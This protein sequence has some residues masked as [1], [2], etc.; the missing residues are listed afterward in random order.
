MYAQAIV[1]LEE[2]RRRVDA[3]EKWCQF[4]AQ[5][6]GASCTW[7]AIFEA[8]QGNEPLRAFTL[9]LFSK[10]NKVRN[11]VLFNDSYGRTHAE[12]LQAFDNTIAYAQRAMRCIS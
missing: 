5:G 2:S 7:N 4:C 10:V 1:V 9:T 8:T 6:N 12:V 3:P 11:V